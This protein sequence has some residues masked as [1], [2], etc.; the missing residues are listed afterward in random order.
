[1]EKYGKTKKK[2]WKDKKGKVK[3]KN[4]TTKRTRILTS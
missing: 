4:E 3:E 2:D 1:M